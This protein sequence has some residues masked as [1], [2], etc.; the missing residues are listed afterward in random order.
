[1]IF[2][3]FPSIRNEVSIQS[4]VHSLVWYTKFKSA[5]LNYTDFHSHSSCIMKTFNANHRVESRFRM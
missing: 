1:M 2:E 3:N 5:Q 4:H